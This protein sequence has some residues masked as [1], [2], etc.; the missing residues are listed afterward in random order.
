MDNRWTRIFSLKLLNRN[1][2]LRIASLWIYKFNYTIN[3]SLPNEEHTYWYI[4]TPWQHQQPFGSY[5]NKLTGFPDSAWNIN[6][7]F[8]LKLKWYKCQLLNLGLEI[9]NNFINLFRSS[10]SKPWNRCSKEKFLG[11]W[12]FTFSESPF[13][14]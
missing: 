3:L 9:I 5:P 14:R 11:D 2:H 4:G 8:F 1:W 6:I 13:S 7:I 10:W 12:H